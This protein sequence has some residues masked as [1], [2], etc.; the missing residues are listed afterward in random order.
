MKTLYGFEKMRIILFVLCSEHINI[1]PVASSMSICPRSNEQELD[2]FN[3]M[4]Q[5][6]D[7]IVNL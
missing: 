2:Y 5:Y 1:L 3:I 6:K 4:K 7:L